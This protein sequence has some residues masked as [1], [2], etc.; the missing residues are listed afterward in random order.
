ME[1]LNPGQVKKYLKQLRERREQYLYYL[2]QLAFQEGEQGTLAEGPMLDAYR[3]LKDIAEQ[4]SGWEEYLERI[5]VARG[6]SQQPRCPRC[7]ATAAKGAAFCPAC[8]APLAAPTIAAPPAAAAPGAVPPVT[9]PAYGRPV[10]PTAAPP[11]YG[12]QVPP[13]AMYPP[14]SYPSPTGGPAAPAAPVVPGEKACMTCGAPLDPDA[15]FC[16]NCGS[17]V[18]REE[19]G[20]VTT[21]APPGVSAAGGVAPAPEEPEEAPEVGEAG[22]AQPVSPAEQ[23]GEVISEETPA[24]ETTGLETPAVAPISGTCPGCHESVDDPEA[25]FCPHCGARLRQ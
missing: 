18:V 19:G 16:G 20:P 14:Y 15:L 25:L 6:A 4:I 10:P 11:A 3:T 13:A 17:R 7:G 5:R 9:P 1:Q 21:Q 12:A 2:G 22:G 23:L 24:A 8:G